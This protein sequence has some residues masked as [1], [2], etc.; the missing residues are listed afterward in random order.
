MNNI[1]TN[2]IE[3]KRCILRRVTLN[4]SKNA[5]NNWMTDKEV[6][7]FVTWELHSSIEVT[8]E[9]FENWVSEYEKPNTYRWGIELKETKELIGVIDVVSISLP[10]EICE[11]GYA[12]SRKSW[13]KG[14]MTEALEAVLDY[15]LNKANFYL[16]Q[17]TY[18]P[19]NIA[20]GRVIEKNGLT[21]I[22]I[23][24]KFAKNKDG[25]RSDLILYAINRDEFNKLKKE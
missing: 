13:G 12:L 16:V 5:F 9:L 8:K 10:K 15:L 21:K 24:P 6:A 4:D 1:G 23:L 25:S 7:K 17:I 14:I 3:T 2:T 20:S 11:I 19:K 22:A 18:F